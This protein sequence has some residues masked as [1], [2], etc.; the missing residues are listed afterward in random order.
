MSLLHGEG[1]A[2]GRCGREPYEELT[3]VARWAIGVTAGFRAW[4]ARTR[5]VSGVRTSAAG[6]SARSNSGLFRGSCRSLEAADDLGHRGAFE[7]M[8]PKPERANAHAAERHLSPPVPRGIP[9]E[10]G[11]PIVSVVR[12]NV[13]VEWAAVPKA[14]IGEHGEPQPRKVKVR[15]SGEIWVFTDEAVREERLQNIA[16][17]PFW[18]GAA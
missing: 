7:F 11:L 8:F 12:W 17:S 3:L 6:E 13:A 18:R 16:Q 1:G 14:A 4:S 15:P 9:C 10:L 5:S 2:A